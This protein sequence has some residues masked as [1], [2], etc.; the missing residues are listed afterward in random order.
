ML[1]K[2]HVNVNEKNAQAVPCSQKSHQD[3]AAVRPPTAARLCTM[4]TNPVAA[5]G[6][7]GVVVAVDVDPVAPNMTAERHVSVE[8]DA[9]ATANPATTAT[10]TGIDDDYDRY[11][12]GIGL[13]ED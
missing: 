2:C 6:V 8:V 12:R 13:Q 11:Y 3:P 4:T 10:T 5:A 7:T 9:A 1:C